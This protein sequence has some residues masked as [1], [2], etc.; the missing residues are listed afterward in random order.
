MATPVSLYRA[1]ATSVPFGG[2]PIIAIYGPVLGGMVAN[3]LNA[4]DQD[5]EIAEALYL[6][7][8]NAAALGETATTVAV[9]PGQTYPLPANFTGNVSVNA[10]SSGHQFSA[11]LWQPPTP[12]PP[13]PQPGPWPPAG[14]TGLTAIIRSSLYEEY[15]DDD[16]LQAF[17]GSYNSLAQQYVDWFNGVPLPVYTSP[18]VTGGLLDWVAEGLYGIVRPALS[19]GQSNIIGPFN[20][21]ALNTIPFDTRETIG[22]ENI[23]VTTDDIFKRIIT[24]PLFKG[25][26]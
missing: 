14:P 6:D 11:V 8:V 20:T 24:W 9:Q 17:V 26:G 5:L 21:Y 2:E 4:A 3:P 13:A 18:Q 7:L 22:P 15:A 1:A 16:D 23:V 19:S 25:D 10:A 12:F